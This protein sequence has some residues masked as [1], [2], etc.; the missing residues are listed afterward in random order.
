MLAFAGRLVLFLALLGYR[1]AESL[2]SLTVRLILLCLNYVGKNIRLLF[3]DFQSSF[4]DFN[5]ETQSS[6]KYFK[7]KTSDIVSR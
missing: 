5:T 4:L 1:I 6:P 7:I 2:F 3:V